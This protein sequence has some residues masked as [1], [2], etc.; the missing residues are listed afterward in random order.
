MTK[1]RI[2]KVSESAESIKEREMMSRFE[3]VI[4]A[5]LSL[6]YGDGVTTEKALELLRDYKRTLVDWCVADNLK[7][8][9]ISEASTRRILRG[10]VTMK[11]MDYEEER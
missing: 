8:Y 3:S 4:D 10:I 2:L 1:V 7:R 9:G 6:E 5:I 11:R